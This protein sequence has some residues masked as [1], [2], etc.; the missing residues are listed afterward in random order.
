MKIIIKTFALLLTLFFLLT[1][2]SCKK[3]DSTVDSGTN[4][5]ERSQQQWQDHWIEEISPV[6]QNLSAINFVDDEN[7]W[8]VGDLSQFEGAIEKTTD[9][10]KHWE[11]GAKTTEFLSD[12]D[13]IDKKRGCAVGYA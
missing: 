11:K 9:G 1:F 13:F 4:S 5:S 10:G 7:G 12:V 8:I 3:R 6:E 2:I